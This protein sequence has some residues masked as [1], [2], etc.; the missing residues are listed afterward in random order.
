M[1]RL[2]R[3]K[4]MHTSAYTDARAFVDRYLPATPISVAD[5][6]SYDFNGS[7]K[8][9]FNR[10]GWSYL[11]FDIIPG[12]N[13]DSVL[14]QP[15]G[16]GESMANSF[17]VAVSTQ[18]LEHIERPWDWIKDVAAIVK[19]GGLIYICTPH[20]MH[21]HAHPKDFWRVWPDGMK[22]LLESAGLTVIE[23]RMQ[24]I[25]TTGIARKEKP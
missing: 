22:A 21:Y 4:I 8:P 11:G 1:E 6:G 24:N 12:P 16:W 5:I 18:V 19:P 17:D 15:Y 23:A 3:V 20:T 9:L 2:Y 13:V 14:T 7:L 25:D 10:D